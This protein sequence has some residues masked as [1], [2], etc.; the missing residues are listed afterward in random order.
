MAA[1][2]PITA[3]LAVLSMVA[4]VTT[5][6]YALA[7]ID[8]RDR[9]NGLS[10]LLFVAG[11]GIWNAMVVV[12]LLTPEP[13]VKLFFLALSV[14]GA[15]L[16][17]LG[18][19]LFAATASSTTDRWSLRS[20]YGAVG[21]LAGLDIAL[22][23]IAP[24]HD[25]YWVAA[26][27]GLYEFASVTPAAGYWFHTALLAALFLAGGWL[28]YGAWSAGTNPAYTR[29]YVVAAAATGVAVVAGGI[30]TPGGHGAAPIVAVALTTV[31]WDQATRGRGLSQFRAWL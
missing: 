26:T 28:F 29:A 10:F 14:V 23:V 13:E 21:I 6:P 20:V 4:V 19:F 16:A 30:L 27:G 9:D 5:V 12:Q 1:I 3:A 15:N 17:G 25:L 7:A 31:G 18:W 24:V 11:V 8:Y 2:V 22:A